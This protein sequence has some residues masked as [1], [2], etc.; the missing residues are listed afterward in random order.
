MKTNN[1][2]LSVCIPTRNRV[3]M[4]SEL[5]DS[6]LSDLD[7]TTRSKTEIVISD[8]NSDD[9]TRECVGSYM[10]QHSAVIRYSRNESDLGFSKNF[11]KAVELATGKFI[12]FMSDDDG[13]EQGTIPQI[14]KIITDHPDVG[15]VYLPHQ[16]YNH[17][18][19]QRQSNYIPGENKFYQR[20][21]KLAEE[22]KAL[23]PCLISGYVVNRSAWLQAHPE[24]HYNSIEI[25]VPVGMKILS[26]HPAYAF[27]ERALIKYRLDNA[28]WSI[29]TDPLFPF[30]L[31]V[32]NLEACKAIKGNVPNR[33]YRMLYSISMRTLAGHVIRNKVLGYPFPR[34][35]ISSILTPFTDFHGLMPALASSIVWIL[36]RT[37]KWMLYVPFRW[38]VPKKI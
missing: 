2:L 7:G 9:G 28:T 24:E 20:G 26:R 19:D 6:V 10:Q 16:D 25:Q 29:E 22:A 11:N 17:Q 13:I 21:Y 23:T 30:P 34:K 5:I 31:L 3:K 37:P 32:G 18:L 15:Y 36:L 14:F 8:N 33:V 12:L 4:L 27:R 1:I 38:L 35:K